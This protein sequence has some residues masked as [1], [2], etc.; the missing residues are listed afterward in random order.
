[1]TLEKMTLAEFV[2]KINKQTEISVENFGP[3]EEA[4]RL[5]DI[6]VENKNK[7]I[8]E[9]AEKIDNEILYINK[10]VE[11]INNKILYVKIVQNL[12]KNNQYKFLQEENLFAEVD[13][14]SP[15]INSEKK[16]LNQKWH[17]LISCLAVLDISSFDENCKNRFPNY[18][19]YNIGKI[20]GIE[21]EKGLSIKHDKEVNKRRVKYYSSNGM[22]DFIRK[23][24]E[25]ENKRQHDELVN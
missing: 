12:N 1:M 20:T 18:N 19:N 16:E 14:F 8:N 9:L 4:K 25:S 11:K 22:L 17:I 24:L 6:F 7:D 15:Y 2:E 23:A 21:L 13:V 10:L 5:A 3:D